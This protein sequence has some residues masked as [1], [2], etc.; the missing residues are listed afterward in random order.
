MRV[1]AI[2][3]GGAGSRIVDHLYD[4]DS[5]S[6]VGC[7]SAIAIDTDSNSLL[8][9]RYLPDHA[10][11]HFPSIDPDLHYDACST[12]D[13][14]EIMT[15]IQKMDIIQ[16][17]AIMIFCGTGGSMVEV[18]SAIVPELRKSFIEPIFAVATL[19]C[20]GE[21]T[22]R[23]AK[24]ADDIALINEYTDA[25]IIF[26]NETW[27]EK[28]KE[29]LSESS[30]NPEN[31]VDAFVSG[32]KGRFSDNP[33]D[34]YFLLNEKIARMIGLLLRA[35]E[36]NEAGLEISEVVLD[37][38][39]VLNTLK[40]NG[41][42]A[43]G[44]ASE[45]IPS[46]KFG[47]FERWRSAKYFIE[48]SQE[49]AARIVSLA[50][51][52]V[53]EDISVPCDL[54]SADKALILIAGPSKELSMKGFQTVRKWIDRSIAGL[55]MRSGDYPVR[56]TRFVGI[57]IMLSGLENIPRIRDLQEI[58]EEYRIELEREREAK[59][60]ETGQWLVE[61]IGEADDAIELPA[62]TVT[63]L[64][65]RPEGDIPISTGVVIL[66]PRKHQSDQFATGSDG[67]VIL[68]RRGRKASG[69][70]RISVP[71]RS[72][73]SGERETHFTR[74]ASAG[75]RT[76]PVDQGM[77]FSRRTSAGERRVPNDGALGARGAALRN[78]TQPREHD[79]PLHVRTMPKAR[80]GIIDAEAVL[81]GPAPKKT[82]EG[83]IDASKVSV[84]EKGASLHELLTDRLTMKKTQPSHDDLF[85]RSEK[86]LKTTHTQATHDDLFARSEKRL[87][88]THT[89]PAQD[90]LFARS[91][92]RLRTRQIQSRD[93]VPARRR[94]RIIEPDEENESQQN[95]QSEKEDDI[96]WIK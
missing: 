12:I 24:A 38:G 95:V 8:Q 63:D 17:D 61:H 59:R 82:K 18:I 67:V 11:V 42:V 71:R 1:L 49:R 44:Y 47:F 3:L 15:D 33:R 28:L 74:M 48:G 51:K 10:K 5:R 81:V 94:L 72:N 89:Q 2:G 64:P 65:P 30:E 9:L 87:K 78:Q 55:E 26:D 54:T 21:G 91:E 53:Y 27:Y 66:P 68:E 62:G 16:I 77:Y 22:A 36:F 70:S 40:G 50:K 73:E 45:E 83:I 56:N 29:L 6:G 34:V 37:A 23:S 46:G 84:S 76:T 88:T 13:L 93:P 32:V 92:K 80:E 58:R 41:N 7:M 57:I 90:D 75:D 43:V 35:G 79:I 20:R 86:R 31:R 52:A 14:E 96:F 19:P 85:A 4:H 25:A 60:S 69:E 39:E